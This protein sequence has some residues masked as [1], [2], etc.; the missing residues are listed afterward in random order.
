MPLA[1]LA[2]LILGALAALAVPVI[3]HLIQRERKEAQQ[4]PS[5]MFLSQVPYKSTRRRQIRNVAL[6][7]LRSAALALIVLAFARPWFQGELDSS[8]PLATASEK[9]ILVD[10][11]YS[12]AYGDR[13]DRAVTA[14]TGAID[15]LGPEDVATVVL[16]DAGAQAMNQ[17]T[18]D[19]V[20][21]R[22]A[23]SGATPGSGVT[24]Y[25]PALK[26]A[27]SIL[28][29]SE[30]PRREVIIVSDFQRAG[31]DGGDGVRMPAGTEVTSVAIT[32]EATSDIA[33]AG[34]TLRREDVGDRERVSAIAR[35]INT[36]GEPQSGVGVTLEL[37][38]RDIET[39]TTDIGA[40]DAATV[41][42]APF[43]LA[44]ANQ[45]GSIRVE[46]DRLTADDAHRFVLSPGQA[47]DVFVADGGGARSTLYL[48]RALAIGDQPRFRSTTKTVNNVR[49]SDFEGKEVI[50]W[51]DAAFPT[52]ATADALQSF[53]RAGGG[54]VVVLG[55]RGSQDAA[56]ELFPA[57]IGRVIDR[58]DAGGALGFIDYGHEIFEVFRAPRS[59]DLSAARFFRYR[60]VTDVG[61]ATDVLARFDDGA[62]AIL[63][64][65]VGAGRVI[66]VTSTLDN[67]WNDLPVQP[68][69][70]PLLHQVIRYSAGWIEPSPWFTVGQVVNVAGRAAV[71]T[72]PAAQDTADE[73]TAPAAVPQT[74]LVAIAPGGDRIDI[75]TGLLS[76]EKAGFYEVRSPGSSANERVVAV[77]VDLTESDLVSMDAQ[78]LV[79]AV[80]PRGDAT[81]RA[82]DA[83]RVSPEDRERR[84]AIW[85]YLLIVAFVFLAVETVWA[86]RMSRR[87]T[88]AG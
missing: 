29:A 83:A 54:L 62:P 76:L 66:V 24:R 87:H 43:T 35:L 1:F 73:G 48:E 32:D 40:A 27:Q 85:W 30:K 45:R 63:E 17:A 79:A 36:A 10:R 57:T 4:F 42:F 23:V 72:S 81:S 19:R 82:D 56:G 52:G 14:A 88:A 20:R 84:Q 51:N 15:G 86:N 33:V 5:L 6:F 71:A 9:V 25:G 55:P 75:E 53:V 68:V 44:D 50:V 26:L 74:K 64:R 12:M 37:N 21:L 65:R 3:V 22:A 59:G 70:L 18:S 41:T 60:P 2:P 8:S 34:V 31:W 77:N 7:L 47:V 69:F 16:F 80:R 58:D 38:G 46:P 49:A 28:D 39:L 13:W 67:Y 78:E 61:S 11:S